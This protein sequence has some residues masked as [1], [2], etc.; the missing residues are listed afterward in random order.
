MAPTSSRR[1]ESLQ[2]LFVQTPAQQVPY[3]GLAPYSAGLY[4]F[5]I[6]VPAVPDSDVVP[7]TF[8]LSSNIIF[9]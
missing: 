7:L 3:A 5:H 4:Q 1:I 6:A 2:F 9:G 8:T